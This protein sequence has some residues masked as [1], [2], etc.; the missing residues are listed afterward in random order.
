MKAEVRTHE[1]SSPEYK[2]YNPASG[3]VNLV[4]DRPGYADASSP[5]LACRAIYSSVAG[6]IVVRMN[7]NADPLSGTAVTL[8]FTAGTTL[9]IQA[10]AIESTGST[11]TNC[12][13]M[14]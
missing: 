1:H 10:V 8:T 2:V 11:A 12:L 4:T 13:V 3:D 6:D 9:P 14:W 7:D 5:R